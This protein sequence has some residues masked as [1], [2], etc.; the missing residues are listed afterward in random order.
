MIDEI[1]SP[2]DLSIKMEETTLK[3]EETPFVPRIDWGELRANRLANQAKKWEGLPT[4]TKMFYEECEAVKRRS[5]E[6]VEKF[7]A[8]SNNISVQNVGEDVEERD[9]PK[10]VMTFDQAFKNYPDILNE[11]KRVGFKKPTPIQ[12]Q[13]WPVLLSGLNLI[14]IAQTG[15]GKTLAFLLP[16]LIHVNGQVRSAATPE[17]PNVLVLSPTRELA[18]QLEAEVNKLHYKGIRRYALQQGSFAHEIYNK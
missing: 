18:L 4:I 11:L 7:R 14:G 8:E 15:T 9:I 3:T 17:G 12:C 10:P 1:I 6:E 13:S 2:Q 5:D 16:A